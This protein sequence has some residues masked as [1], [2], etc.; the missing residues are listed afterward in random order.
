MNAKLAKFVVLVC[1]PTAPMNSLTRD[2]EQHPSDDSCDHCLVSAAKFYNLPDMLSLMNESRSV[3]LLVTLAKGKSGR[4][5]GLRATVMA[6]HF[7]LHPTLGLIRVAG[8][9]ANQGNAHSTRSDAG[10]ESPN[11]SH[12]GS[13]FAVSRVRRGLYVDHLFENNLASSGDY[14][15]NSLLKVIAS[16]LANGLFHSL[17]SK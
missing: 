1:N 10:L 9:P 8:L 4:G 15:L 2:A 6:I 5:G 11:L 7:H 12:P 16:T 17:Q 13:N 14:R 3:D